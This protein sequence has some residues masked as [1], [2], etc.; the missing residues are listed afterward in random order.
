MPYQP[1]SDDPDLALY[2]GGFFDDS[3]KKQFVRIR[4]SSAEQ[5]SRT[6]F[7]FIDSR[8]PEMLF[9]YRARN[10]PHSL[11]AEEQ[12]RWQMHCRQRVVEGKENAL[13]L[14]AYFIALEQLQKTVTEAELSRLAPGFFESL[15]AYGKHIER[16][17]YAGTISTS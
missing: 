15:H 12:T 8:L 14:N 6:D 1:D 7:H 17:V 3:D 9:R 4:K 16:S 13:T 5:L 10:F 11:T 2:S